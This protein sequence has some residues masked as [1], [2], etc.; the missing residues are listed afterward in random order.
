MVIQF[1]PGA[2][3]STQAVRHPGIDRHRLEH[4]RNALYEQ[5]RFRLEQLH[6]LAASDRAASDQLMEVEVAL[7]TA[8]EAALADID[9]ALT[10][11]GNG[12]YGLCARCQRPILPERLAILPAAALCMRCQQN[13]EQPHR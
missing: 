8:A 12:S 5:R 10:R 1:S 4:F 9:A 11:V 6:Q 3:G 2:D 13:Q 7:R